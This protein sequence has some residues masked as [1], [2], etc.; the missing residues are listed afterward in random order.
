[1]SCDSYLQD[2]L[3]KLQKQGTLGHDGNGYTLGADRPD[4]EPSA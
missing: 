3:A 2:V 1:L 4:E